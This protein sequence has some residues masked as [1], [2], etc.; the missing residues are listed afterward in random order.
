MKGTSFSKYRHFIENCFKILPRQALHAKTLGFKHPV[1]GEDLI[2]IRKL[3]EDFMVFLKNGEV[4]LLVRVY[5]ILIALIIHFLFRQLKP[6]KFIL[7]F[8]AQ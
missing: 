1:T 2:L 7:K 6:C 8:V 4:I 3:P 5:K